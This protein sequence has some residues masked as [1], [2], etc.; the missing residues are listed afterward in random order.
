MAS[1]Q[2]IAEALRNAHAAG[3]TAAAQKL[4][5]A[6]SAMPQDNY[7]PEGDSRNE[8]AA[9]T[10]SPNKPGMLA[11]GVDMVRSVPG[12]LANAAAGLGGFGGDMRELI[13]AGAGRVSGVFGGDPASNEAAT[14]DAILKMQRFGGVPE[15]PTSTQLRDEITKPFGGMYEPKTTAGKYAETVATFAPNAIAPGS[16]A[17]RMA[18]VLVPGIG[19]EAAGQAAKGS[20]WEPL[21]RAGGALLG[22]IGEGIGEGVISARLNPTMSMDELGKAKTA[23]YKAADQ[24]GVQITP[25][26]WE[27]FSQDVNDQI[28][29]TGLI[30][31]KLHGNTLSALE[32]ISAEAKSGQPIS[33][34]RADVV[35][36]V[37]N[38]AVD[39]SSGP[40]GNGGDMA[41]SMQVK[42]LLDDFLD[43]LEKNPT[44]TL[45]GDPGTAV[46]ILKEARNLAQREFKAKEIQ[47]LIDLAENQASS[48]FPGA[49]KEQA[50]R[51]Q[52]KNFNARLIKDPQLAKSFSDAEREAI[53][54]VAQGGAVGNV[55]RYF[56]KLA[57]TGV[58]SGGAGV[59]LG[60]Y[61]GGLIGGP[62]GGAIGAAAV[63]AFG[64]AAR[65][66][67]TIATSRNARLAEE[68]MRA[69][70]ANPGATSIPRNVM[71]S[72]LLSQ[73]GH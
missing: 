50:L 29:K 64:L 63:P 73:A 21:A 66:G 36:K 69:G 28:T 25:Q 40:N 52:F 2:E 49:G 35:R 32:T 61:G 12:G 27:Q 58:V 24:A 56:G 37:I 11:T 45:S 4:A 20:K 70:E 15:A 19:S 39:A 47:K 16:A 9:L 53:E 62:V 59:G 17:A 46:P 34:S 30:H 68:L 38:D 31:P 71:L 67:A 44:S 7:Y 48:N 41:R 57:P 55:M 1:K 51:V 22:G 26:A 14:R 6:Y 23:A 43:N 54:K 10:V 72:T 8:P 5:D 42:G 65:K 18:R 3:D 13:A 60:A 33:L